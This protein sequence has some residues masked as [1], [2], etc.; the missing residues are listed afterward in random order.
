MG[1]FCTYH[2]LSSNLK[3]KKSEKGLTLTPKQR[4]IKL[5]KNY[6][7]SCQ[8]WCCI[9]NLVEGERGNKEYTRLK[10]NIGVMLGTDA[11]SSL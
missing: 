8:S 7:S 9:Q 6:E 10:S 1:P 5:R 4:A 2:T 3:H 11:M